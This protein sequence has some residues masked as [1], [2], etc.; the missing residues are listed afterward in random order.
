[1]ASDGVVK[2][3]GVKLW[4]VMTRNFRAN[5][6]VSIGVDRTSGKRPKQCDAQE[7]WE[8]FLAT[9]RYCIEAAN[10]PTYSQHPVEMAPVIRVN[11]HA[12]EDGGDEGQNT[13]WPNSA[14][15]SA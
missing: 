9:Y 7:A 6:C 4:S 14:T 2:A 11:L 13:R 12:L 3:V 5:G 8:L 1:M 15:A 10:S